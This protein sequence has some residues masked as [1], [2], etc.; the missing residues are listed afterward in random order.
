VKRLM[1]QDKKRL[2]DDLPFFDPPVRRVFDFERVRKI[3]RG[4]GF[5]SPL[6]YQMVIKNGR[7]DLPTNPHLVYVKE[8]EGWDNFLGTWN[9]FVME[10]EKTWGNTMMDGVLG[11]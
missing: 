9:I 10:Y 5:Q 3:V 7:M 2:L 4:M 11:R 6:E 8:W 1:Q